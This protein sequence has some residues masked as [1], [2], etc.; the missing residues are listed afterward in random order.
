LKWRVEISFFPLR[1]KARQAT[2]YMI[3]GKEG[4][5]FLAKTEDT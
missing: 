5:T 3:N 2:Y 1:C 4:I